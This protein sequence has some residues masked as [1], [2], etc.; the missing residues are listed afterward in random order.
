M[1]LAPLQ[2]VSS[3]SLDGIEWVATTRT[4][5][6]SS[7]GDN[8]KANATNVPDVTPNKSVIDAPGT[9]TSP[10]DDVA[11]TRVVKPSS[12]TESSSES[13]S[14]SKSIDNNVNGTAANNVAAS[15]PIEIPIVV[16]SPKEEPVDDSIGIE[17]SYDSQRVVGSQPFKYD[18][19]F[20]D[21]MEDVDLE[22]ADKEHKLQLG[23]ASLSPVGGQSE[24]GKQLGDDGLYK[25][26][27]L[28]SKNSSCEEGVEIQHFDRANDG[29]RKLTVY[30]NLRK[31]R[32][33]RKKKR[34][35]QTLLVF[36]VI[37]AVGFIISG[38]LEVRRRANQNKKLSS[39][40]TA[41]EPTDP[42]GTKLPTLWPTASP[43]HSD[44][45]WNLYHKL[46]PVLGKE[47]PPQNSLQFAAMDWMVNF[48]RIGMDFVTTPGWVVIERFIIV[49]L[50]FSTGAGTWT[51]QVH[52]LSPTSVCSWNDIDREL[53]ILCDDENHVIE[54]SMCK[55][56][57]NLQI[58][59]LCWTKTI[60]DFTNLQHSLPNFSFTYSS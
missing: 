27:S 44:E 10:H 51:N 36:L 29:P 14:S 55:C 45:F 21:L 47:I 5:D 39:T 37:G 49:L 46:R 58:F 16:A 30:P 31:W 54:V 11:V 42:D 8:D 53:G 38:L 33:Y 50:Y 12:S 2:S 20:D 19:I 28:P 13:S 18:D 26:Y 1:P 25:D 32:F 15:A 57:Q 6:T 17:M 23:A 3:D 4:T 56:I 41:P 35:V 7:I 34:M 52:F 40:S 24:H 48:D 59:S 22:E 43:T 60:A 9:T